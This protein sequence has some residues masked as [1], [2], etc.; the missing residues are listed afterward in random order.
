M[1]IKKHTLKK[2]VVVILLATIFLYK[3][4]VLPIVSYA[5]QTS[6]I[7][8]QE[9]D[10]HKESDSDTCTSNIKTYTKNNV[11]KSVRNYVKNQNVDTSNNIV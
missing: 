8:A 10:I 7:I 4:K 5:V 1:N 9:I 3:G 2:I 11:Y 6:E